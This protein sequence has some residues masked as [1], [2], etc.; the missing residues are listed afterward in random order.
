MLKVIYKSKVYRFIS[1]VGL[2]GKE[3]TAELGGRF[4]RLPTNECN[5]VR[6]SREENNINENF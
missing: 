1:Y 2:S 4:F 5:I 6:I 3:I